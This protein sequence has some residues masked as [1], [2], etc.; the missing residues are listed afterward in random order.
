MVEPD[1][2]VD[3]LAEGWHR[4]DI[5]FARSAAGA[6]Q[7]SIHEATSEGFPP[8]EAHISRAMYLRLLIPEILRDARWALYL[9]ADTLVRHPISH[10]PE[11]SGFARSGLPIAGVQDSEVPYLGCAPGIRSWREDGT[12][13]RAPYINTGVLLMDLDL[14][15]AEGIGRAALE[16]KR[17][18]PEAW[19]DNDAINAVLAGRI[20]RVPRRWNA[21]TH[22]MRTTSG[23]FGFDEAH[24]VEVARADPSVVHF[25]GAVKPWHSNAALPFLGEWRTVAASLGWT[26]FRHSFTVRRRAELSLIRLIDS[27]SY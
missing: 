25:T 6:A 26:R 19:T 1:A 14:W 22:M 15:R 12:D 11:L 17:R 10:L 23:V 18:H 13:P 24:E 16:W 7:L 5:E 8:G 20:L 21:T 9:D 3:I 27:S 2:R 4:S